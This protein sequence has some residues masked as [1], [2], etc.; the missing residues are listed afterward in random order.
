MFKRLA[1][2]ICAAGLVFALCGCGGAFDKEYVSVAD[3]VPSTPDSAAIEERV[4]V[5]SLY[6]LKQAILALVSEGAGEGSIYFD[7]SYDGEASEDMA[8]ACWQ[9]RTQDA[10]CAYCVENIAYELNKIVTYYEA[11]VNVTYSNVWQTAGGI[12]RL[13]Y[14]TGV[15]DAVKNALYEG[16]T[17]LV[18]LVDSSTIN[19]ENMEGLV[20]RVY[21]KY[22]ASAPKMPVAGVNIYSGSGMQRLYEINIDYGMSDEELELCREKM[23]EL[24]PFENED[25][26]AMDEAHKAL[27]AA[28][29]LAEHCEYS[30]G[31]HNGS[32][33]S[34]LIYGKADSEGAALAYVELCR[35]LNVECEIVYGQQSWQEHC[36]NIVE[37]DGEHYHV[38]LSA[39]AEGGMEAGF[40]LSD[41]QMWGG[42][43][44]D[45]SSYP[46]CS[47][48]LSLAELTD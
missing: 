34:A 6:E 9:V 27:L 43:R 23:A 39:C 5:S 35:R 14:S 37:I 4:T 28:Q 41:E 10:L 19:A 29:Y 2:L 1:V 18:I 17:K 22:P 48:S 26:E 45:V 25:A 12:V 11:K 30:E 36:W 13:K 42:H 21:R 38:D 16:D 32:V 3:Y 7:P 33:Y 24:D 47:G 46:V 8:T 40:L 20:A 44:W 15:E 31:D